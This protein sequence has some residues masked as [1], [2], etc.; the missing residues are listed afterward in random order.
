MSNLSELEVKI[1]YS[2]NDQALL[3]EAVTHGST[4]NANLNLPHHERLE[5]LGDAI[6]YTVI[7]EYLFKKYPAASPGE[8]STKRQVLI[9]DKKQ[10]ALAE[11]LEL[12]EHVVMNPS[13]SRYQFQRY[14]EFVE[15]IIGAVYMDAGGST[16]NGLKKAKEVIFHLWQLEDPNTTGCLII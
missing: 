14:G 6:L 1:G 15:A 4:R 7:S 2:F 11:E 9:T 12:Y 8:L 13:V 16:V 10:N 5:Y 3:K